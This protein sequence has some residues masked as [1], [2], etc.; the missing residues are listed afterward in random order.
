M[1]Q[2]L[3]TVAN[4]AADPGREQP[5]AEL[6]LKADEYDRIRDILGRRPTSSELAMYSVMWSEHCSYKSSKVHLKQFGEIAQETPVGK[7]LAGIGENAG[8]LDI[9]QG[10]QLGRAAPQ[11]TTAVPVPSSSIRASTSGGGEVFAQQVRLP[12]AVVV[13]GARHEQAMAPRRGGAGTPGPPRGCPGGRS[14][15]RPGRRRSSP[16]RCAPPRSVRGRT[17]RDGRTPGRRRRHGPVRRRAPGPGRS[18]ARSSASAR[19][20]SS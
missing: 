16:G 15:A 14:P 17:R 8:V 18:A 7:M 13:R 6:G 2:P 20:G 9:G 5:W 1:P 19:S 4:A 11:R 10:Y 3:D 12:G